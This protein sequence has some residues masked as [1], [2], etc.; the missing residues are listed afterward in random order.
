MQ[1]KG[2]QKTLKFSQL[3]TGNIRDVFPLL[4]PVR[5]KDWL[6]GWDYKMIYSKSGLIEQDCVFSTPYNDNIE[7]FWQVTQYDKT[8]FFIEFLRVTP[9]ENIVKINI[10]LEVVD[11]QNT[12]SHISYQYTALNEKQNEFIRNNLENSFMESMNWWEKAINYYLQ[13][14]KMLKR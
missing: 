11:E 8:N 1:F 13:N 5:E 4:F 7:T 9:N 10:Q 3:N 12:K 2:I 14:G 6:D